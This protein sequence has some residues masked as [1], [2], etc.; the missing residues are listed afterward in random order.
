MSRAEAPRAPREHARAQGRADASRTR[1]CRTRGPCAGRAQGRARASRSRPRRTRAPRPRRDGAE[2]ARR[3]PRRATMPGRGDGAG[4]QGRA[5][6]PWPC[7]GA[8]RGGRTRRGRRGRATPWPKQGPRRHAMAAPWSVGP[9]P[10]RGGRG[11]PGPVGRGGRGRRARAAPG[12]SRPGHARTVALG[13]T[14]PRREGRGEGD[15]EGGGLPQGEEEGGL[16]ARGEADV[17]GRFWS[18]AR[19]R[20]RGALGPFLS[21][22]V[23]ECQHKCLNVNLYP[24]MDKV[25]IKSKRMFLSLSTLF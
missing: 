25:Q 9:R 5:R 15:E 14:T 11:T 8:R 23:I 3:A 6:A 7:R 4:C 19:W 17:E 24:W 21:I 12:S 1:W 2:R 16:T 13:Q 22:L 18:A 20:G 10:G